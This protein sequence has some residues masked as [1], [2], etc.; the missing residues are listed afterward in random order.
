[1]SEFTS[2]FK[3]SSTEQSNA[4]NI[5]TS[6]TEKTNYPIVLG[7]YPYLS[8]L[9]S[10]VK[11]ANIVEMSKLKLSSAKLMADCLPPPPSEK[12]LAELAAKVAAESDHKAP[13][14][15]TNIQGY[16]NICC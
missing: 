6:N 4:Q 1:M 15:D 10:S 13:E 12:E 16:S 3:H 11:S 7:N 2:N 9:R 5:Q 8:A 14:I